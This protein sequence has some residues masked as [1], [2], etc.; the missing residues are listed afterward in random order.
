MG[1][2][3]DLYNFRGDM[4]VGDRLYNVSGPD[5]LGFFPPSNHLQV[6]QKMVQKVGNIQRLAIL[7]A[8]IPC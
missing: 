6:L 1:E 3:D 4:A 2:K 5:L 8:K 7:W